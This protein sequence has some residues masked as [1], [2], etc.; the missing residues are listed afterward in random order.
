MKRFFILENEVVHLCP[1]GIKG[2][3]WFPGK[4]DAQAPGL[5]APLLLI[6]QEP[7]AFYWWFQHLGW[8]ISLLQKLHVFH[9]IKVGAPQDLV[10]RLLLFPLC[11]PS[12]I[13]L[14]Q[15]NTALISANWFFPHVHLCCSLFP[16]LHFFISICEL[17]AFSKMLRL[18]VPHVLGFFLKSKTVWSAGK[19]LATNFLHP[20]YILCIDYHGVNIPSWLT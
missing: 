12:L 1:S 11:I 5:R 15:S 13:S 7:V 8:L 9:S 16:V 17:T 20:W 10:L 3:E 2:I 6:V 19:C 14:I 18:Q 4:R